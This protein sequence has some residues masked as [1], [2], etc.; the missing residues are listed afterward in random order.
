MGGGGGGGGGGGVWGRASPENFELSKHY[1]AIFSVLE[2]KLRTKER[3]F[4]PRK[5][6]YKSQSLPASNE[7]MMKTKLFNLTFVH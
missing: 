2:T 4:H 6:I 1:N 3:V 5:L 7:Q